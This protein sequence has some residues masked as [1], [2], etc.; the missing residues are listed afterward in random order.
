[1]CYLHSSEGGIAVVLYQQVSTAWL[2][3]NTNKKDRKCEY[4]IMS[5]RY[6]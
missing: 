3:D 6:T 5:C 4:K 2:I 1:M